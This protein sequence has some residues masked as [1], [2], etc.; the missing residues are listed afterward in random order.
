MPSSGGSTRE[1]VEE[2]RARHEMEEEIKQQ[3]AYAKITQAENRNVT[4]LGLTKEQEQLREAWKVLCVAL[5]TDEQAIKEIGKEGVKRGLVN[6]AYLAVILGCELDL[7]GFAMAVTGYWTLPDQHFMK[8]MCVLG[9]VGYLLAV[10]MYMCYSDDIRSRQA[11]EEK[12]QEEDGAAG[13]VFIKVQ[14]FKQPITLKYY[15]FLPV[16]RYYL[17]VKDKETDDIE[18]VFRVNSL[19]SF[20][21]GI[22]QICGIIFYAIANDWK[23]DFFTRVNIGS[24]CINWFL[25]FLYFMT[26]I[27]AKMAAAMK[28][29]ALIYNS[30]VRLRRLWQEYLTLVVQNAN[31]GGGPETLGPLDNFKNNIAREILVLSN[32]DDV[33]LSPFT[34]EEKFKTLRFLHDRANNIY[35]NI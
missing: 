3:E 29:E 26:P 35:S 8:L 6:L 21:L 28:V 20:S 34:M 25:T 5:G 2:V 4:S 17:V 32:V 24:Q 15:H 18:G 23:L 19:S 22:A 16:F 12:Q 31:N 14:N 11:E 33:D 7:Y 1:S 27:S 30:G 9:P 10:I 13:R